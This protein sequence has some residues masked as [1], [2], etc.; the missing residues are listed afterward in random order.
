MTALPAV[1]QRMNDDHG[2]FGR[3]S[4]DEDGGE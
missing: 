3:A 1:T 2:D 4:R